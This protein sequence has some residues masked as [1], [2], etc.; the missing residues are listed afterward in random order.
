MASI[1]ADIAGSMFFY[2]PQE[3]GFTRGPYSQYL[4]LTLTLVFTK[5][6]INVILAFEWI[7]Y[8]VVIATIL[9]RP[10]LDKRI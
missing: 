10:D 5:S 9:K 8:A 2:L 3:N 1:A 4:G 6:P 7:A